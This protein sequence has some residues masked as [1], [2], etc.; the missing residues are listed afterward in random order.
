M[1]KPVNE[2][3]NG[4]ING[5]INGGHNNLNGQNSSN[6]SLVNRYSDEKLEYFK[7]L[8]L[9]KLEKSRKALEVLNEDVRG[10]PNGTND[11]FHSFKNLEEGC[12][13]NSKEENSKLAARQE[14]FI[15]HLENALIRIENKSYGICVE[16]GVQIDEDRLRSVT[17]ATLSING[18]EIREA[19]EKLAKRR[20]LLPR[21][22]V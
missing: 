5:Q 8:I 12:Q 21:Q 16:L 13:V 20:K 9:I 17:H 7:Q 4:Q 22:I 1:K 18:K 6:G 14:K 2:K 15:K 10:N 19:R 3:I 11:T